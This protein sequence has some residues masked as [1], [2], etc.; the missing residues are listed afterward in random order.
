MI[1][2]DHL[3]LTLPLLAPLYY[4]WDNVRIL[5]IFQAIWISCSGLAIF[6]YLLL[7]KFTQF[8]ALTLSFI[9]LLFYGIQY[10]LYFDFHPVIIG[11]GLLAWIVYFW[12]SKK[13]KLFAVS[14]VLLLLT[15]ENMG[16]ALAGLSIIWFFQGKRRKLALLMGLIGIVSSFAAF[17]AIK[18]FTDVVGEYSPHLPANLSG[19]V[20]QLFD[21]P[22]KRE[23]LLYSL[24]SFSFLSIFSIGSMLAVFMDLGQYFLTGE[25]F[26]R[27]WSPFTH[28][29]A[30]L[31]IFLLVGAADTLLFLKS[32]KVNIT[33]V[34]GG[35]LLISLFLQF[36]F[37]FPL[38]KLTKPEFLRSESWM[39]DNQDGLSRI[40]KDASVAAQQS[41][42][43]HLS[44]RKEIYLIYPRKHTFEQSVCSQRE[45]WWLDFGGKP[46]YL[47]IDTH[48]GAWLTMLLA[49]VKD[50]REAVNSMENSKAIQLVY[51]KN[52]TKIYRVNMKELK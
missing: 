52:E 16:I 11:V 18:L 1:L 5:L 14:T 3:T 8:Q 23:V 4:L 47:I 49:D 12:E 46:E 44:H 21:S 33:Y 17:Q 26:M 6:K 50:F 45:C 20:T 43:P 28:H 29:R 48:D 36:Y 22:E 39:R 27:M 40:P 32:K 31:D 41:L 10:A 13:W 24:S 2:G 35:M 42:V 19:Y 38:N 25:S 30:I 7:R 9:Y 51:R 37:H 34:V 15:Q